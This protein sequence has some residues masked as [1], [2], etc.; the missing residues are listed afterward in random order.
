[1]TR[2]RLHRR[3]AGELA[4]AARWYGEHSPPASLRFMAAI[5]QAI[6]TIVEAPEAWP[7]RGERADVRTR[8]VA[9]FPYSIVYRVRANEVYILAIAHAKRRP[10]YWSG[11]R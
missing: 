1:V 5:Q 3:A 4:A 10:G 7:R 8:A 9:S 11:R 6:R 2:Y